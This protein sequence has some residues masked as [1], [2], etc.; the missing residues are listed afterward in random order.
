MVPNKPGSQQSFMMAQSTKK[1][2]LAFH[3]N[4]LD[5][6]H[7]KSE[8]NIIAPPRVV[9]YR[10]FAFKYKMH[11]VGSPRSLYQGKHQTRSRKQQDP[12]VARKAMGVDTIQARDKA[13][14]SKGE[15]KDDQ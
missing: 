7:K 9:H 3:Q 4:T 2:W 8:E 13:N 10:E 5:K 12:Q 15:S 6:D 11:K 14:K 1:K